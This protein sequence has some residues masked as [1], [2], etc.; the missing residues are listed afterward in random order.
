MG[1]CVGRGSDPPT[2]VG[3]GREGAGTPTSMLALAPVDDGGVGS[4]GV[5]V[6]CAGIPFVAPIVPD[7]APAELRAFAIAG[8]EAG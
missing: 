1:G 3:V 6:G 4:S 8:R 5:G 2:M 7:E